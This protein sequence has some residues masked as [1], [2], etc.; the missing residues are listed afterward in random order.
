MVFV[1]KFKMLKQSNKIY[2]M[3]TLGA[4]IQ[5]AIAGIT[6]QAHSVAGSFE[7]EK[8]NTTAIQE[9]VQIDLWNA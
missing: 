4:I 5:E 6:N 2:E 1:C 8:P 3:V 9:T 7:S